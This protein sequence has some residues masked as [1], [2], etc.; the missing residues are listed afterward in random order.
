MSHPT[1]LPC[2]ATVH[3]A[4]H[5]RAVHE[6]LQDAKL[7]FGAGRHQILPLLRQD[8]QVCNAP[9]DVLGIV[10][11]GRSQFYQMP[12]APADEIAVALKVA[13]LTVSGTENFGI[14]HGNR[15]FFRYNQ[16]CNKNPS[17]LFRIAIC[18]AANAALKSDG[19]GILL[20]GVLRLVLGGNLKIAL[21]LGVVCI[22]VKGFFFGLLFLLLLHKGVNATASNQTD[23]RQYA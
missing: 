10:D 16:F 3:D 19:F 11:I 23:Q 20:A 1:A 21:V 14:G 8:G 9:L 4:V 6:L 5:I 17:N 13:I 2:I 15:W 22:G 7:L 12:D 18:K